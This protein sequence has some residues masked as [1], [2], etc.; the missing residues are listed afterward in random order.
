MKSTS[1]LLLAVVVLI[2]GLA[3]GC[4][5][6]RSITASGKVT[7][8]GAFKVGGNSSFNVAT[9]PLAE[10]D[11]VTKSA[12]QTIENR[13]SIYFN[14]VRGLTRGLLA[15]SLDPVSAA[16]DFY[17]RYGLAKRVD[18]GY[19][20][21][22]GAH[23]FD[24]MYQFMGGLGTPDNP[25]EAG[26]YGSIGLQY[27]SQDADLPSKL[28]LNRLSNIFNYELS[29][30]D[31]LVPLVFS[32]SFGPEEQYGNISWGLVYGHSFV[33]YGFAPSKLF[34]RVAGDEIRK[35]NPFLEKENFSSYGAFFNAKIGF[36]YA[37]LL[38]ALSM[39]YQNYGTYNLFGLQKESFKGMSFI[40]SLGL[41]INIGYGKAGRR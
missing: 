1:S 38:P 27:S 14:D 5:P 18:V 7:P 4:T 26:L 6:S 30:Q 33:K 29:R 11:G 25:G 20:F 31:I 36:K 13:D 19:K 16:T 23:V 35:V 22:S 12:V 37:Y 40:P 15:Y 9:T 41:Q 28:G 2:T 10:I 32:H 34:V 39:Y 24:A 3:T 17:L 8:K 21:A